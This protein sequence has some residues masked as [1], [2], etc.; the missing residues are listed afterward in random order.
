MMTPV[1]WVGCLGFGV[2]GV[3]AGSSSSLMCVLY[4]GCDQLVS[5]LEELDDSGKSG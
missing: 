5:P 1:R 3:L 4:A 2:Q